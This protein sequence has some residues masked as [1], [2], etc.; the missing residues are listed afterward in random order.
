MAPEQA[1]ARERLDGRADVY[2]LGLMLYEMLVGEA[3]FEAEKPLDLM[4]MQI[5]QAPIRPS[6]RRPEVG[7][8]VEKVVLRALK[9]DP[10]RRYGDMHQF[11][12][13][14]QRCRR[15]LGLGSANVPRMRNLSPPSWLR[16]LF[17]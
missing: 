2:T 5:E 13:A 7:K 6:L 14:L 4:L 3:P 17:S 16:S 8:G 15:Q 11:L 10:R 12:A 1:L 9:K